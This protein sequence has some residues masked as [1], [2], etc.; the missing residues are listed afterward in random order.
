MKLNKKFVAPYK[1]KPFELGYGDMSELILLLKYSRLKPDGNK[2]SWAEIVER[3]VNGL[4]WIVENY[5]DYSYLPREL[6]Q[7]AENAYDDIYNM[8]VLPAG[9]PL[10]NLGTTVVQDKKLG[11]ALYNCAFVSFNETDP[12]TAVE[13]IMDM[14][15][16]GVGVGIDVSIKHTRKLY[17]PIDIRSNRYVIPDTREGWVYALRLLL[18]SYLHE[19][20]Y[21]V[22]FDYSDIRPKGSLIRGMGGIHEGYKP[23]E[24]MLEDIRKVLNSHDTFNTRVAADISNMI[25]VCVVNGGQRRT[26]LL[27][28]G[29]YDDEEFISLK[30]Y[31]TNP[32]RLSFGYTSN[33]SPYLNVGQNYDNLVT[34]ISR[35]EDL[36]AV[37][38]ENART[39]GRM[40]GTIDTSDIK[41]SGFNPCVEIGLE[42]F[43]LC[44]LVEFNPNNMKGEK[45]YEQ[46]LKTAVFIAKVI[47]N[48]EIHWEETREVVRRNR[49]FGISQSGIVEY[50]GKVGI[51]KY[52]TQLNKWYDMVQRFDAEISTRLGIPNSIR[53]TTVKPSGSLSKIMGTSAGVHHAT[54]KYMIRRVEVPSSSPLLQ[55]MVERG[56]KVEPSVYKENVHVVE[57]PIDNSHVKTIDEVS[58]RDQF[59][60]AAFMQE[61]WAD[62]AVSV[63]FSLNKSEVQSIKHLIEEF[64][65]KLKCAS[66]LIRD[67]NIYEQ[68]PEEP[69]SYERF[70]EETGNSKSKISLADAIKGYSVDDAHPDNYCTTDV[71]DL[72]EHNI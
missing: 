67:D 28:L 36:G 63:T 1:N 72:K 16:L 32:E 13:Y 30:D 58:L 66:F 7:I 59:E 57:F 15:M 44:N 60:L 48:M 54:S 12:V 33:N 68:L 11:A 4:L 24:K 39:Y 43:E 69:I 8:R 37:W 42:N 18:N 10:A 22:E 27:L 6:R 47:S 53:T 46:A 35:G 23:L 64:Q 21:R 2:E 65:H 62:N 20:V 5:T 45:E 52:K 51:G 61:N 41:V 55:M 56:Y 34:R 71:C 31:E 29:Q 17:K 25:G 14:S 19:G 49:R 3:V 40:N 38:L 26:A 70:L 50:I 9:R